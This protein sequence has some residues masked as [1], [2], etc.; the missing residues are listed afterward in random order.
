MH[1]Q[2]ITT[3]SSQQHSSKKFFWYFLSFPCTTQ[4]YIYTIFMPCLH[5][6]LYFVKLYIWCSHYLCK[7]HILPT[8][9]KRTAPFCLKHLLQI[10]FSSGERSEKDICNW[11]WCVTWERLDGLPKNVVTKPNYNSPHW[12]RC[13]EAKLLYRCWALLREEPGHVTSWLSSQLFN[14]IQLNHTNTS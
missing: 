10:T 13:C 3:R 1:L 11:I 7:L 4:I 8:S 2:C 12:E 14:T 5:K 9:S 6:L